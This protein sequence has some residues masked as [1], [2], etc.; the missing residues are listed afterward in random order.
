MTSGYDL[1]SFWT[2]TWPDDLPATSLLAGYGDMIPDGRSISDMA[3]GLGKRRSFWKGLRTCHIVMNMN[4]TQWRRLQDF[5]ELDTRRGLDPF[6][7]L[8]APSG[9][10]LT[11]G[12]VPLTSGGSLLTVAVPVLVQFAKGS[13]PRITEVYRSDLFKVEFDVDVLP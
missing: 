2:V 12:G 8:D 3:S 13:S 10:T 9:G 7:M 4:T 5:W 11:E 6:A 1:G